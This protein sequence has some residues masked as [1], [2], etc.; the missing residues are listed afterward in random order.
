[1]LKL[2]SSGIKNINVFH[3]TRFTY[4]GLT[5]DDFMKK[6]TNEPV[7]TYKK[8]S[9]EREALEE[10]LKEM[11]TTIAEVPLYVGTKIKKGPLDQQQI[12][13][14]DKKTVIA[15]FS[16]ATSEDINEAIE[17]SLSVREEWSKKSLRERA[18]IFL[19][20]AD[21]CAGKYRMQLNAA[22]MLGQG[23]TIVQAEIDAA[24]ELI[25]F[26]R[27]NAYFA[28]D[29]EKYKPISTSISKN[30]MI[31]RPMEGFVASIAPFNFTAIG[32]NLA[33]AP[34]LAGN[35]VIFKPSS[36][37]VLSNSIFMKAFEEAGLPRGV[38]SF[39]PANGPVFGNTVTDHSH[40][41]AI[42]FTGSVPTFVHL[43]K[44][45]G[46]KLGKGKYITFPKLIGE[47]GGKNFHFVHPSADIQSVVN[48]TILSSFEYSGQKCSAC[49]RVY[50]P[51][52]LWA[53]FQ[54]EFEKVHKQ[55]KLGDV[56][57]GD[58][59]LSSVIDEVAFKRI[60]KYIDS[61][62]NKED[63]TEIVFGGKYDSSKGYFIQPTLVKVS[64]TKAKI[65]TQEI[66]GPVVSV[67]V[68]NDNEIDSVLDNVKDDTQYGLTGA[69]FSR[70]EVFLKKAALKLRDAVGNLYLNDK[71][72]GSIVG[73][74][75]FG[76]ARMSGTND[77]AGGPHYFLKWTSPQTIK[78]TSV[79]LTTWKYPSME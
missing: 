19:D 38:I 30:E 13:P 5:S 16:D 62:K 26:L 33:S 70:D 32:G 47:C 72:T 64:S 77:K 55:L 58:S 9:A 41:A 29:L 78:T 69:V 43:W 7:M 79:P 1:M 48:G 45:V 61:A 52:S 53:K 54:I 22:T 40:L 27:F 12:M 46:E 18:E 49:S 60:T 51:K 11:S 2:L 73:Q 31:Y 25:D 34:A 65:F 76:G 15:K 63:G 21:L 67:Y 4:T 6:P 36:T 17:S 71:S 50:L 42:N 37:A 24:C 8:G 10:A 57:E 66:F 39:L 23:K 74:Q 20:A 28:L 75:P 56:R 68:Y 59:F 35:V 44:Q 3:R 14:S